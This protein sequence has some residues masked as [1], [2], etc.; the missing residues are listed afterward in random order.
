MTTI[1]LKINRRTKAGKAFMAMADSFLKNTEGIEIVEKTET[2][3]NKSEIIRKLSEKINK[4]AT[5]RMLKTH[6]L[7]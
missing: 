4:K 1:T 6:G 7:Q 3:T 2:T 5:E